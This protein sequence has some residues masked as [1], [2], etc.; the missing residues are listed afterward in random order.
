M[1]IFHE[2]HITLDDLRKVCVGSNRHNFAGNQT[3]YL[4]GIVV[5]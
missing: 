5:G 2:Y 3:A 4:S 1:F